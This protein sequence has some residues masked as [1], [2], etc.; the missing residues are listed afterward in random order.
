MV[1]RMDIS[2]R[3]VS[4]LQEKDDQKWGGDVK[5]NQERNQTSP[6]APLEDKPFPP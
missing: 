6:V 5:C 3:V 4:W 2:F 1:G